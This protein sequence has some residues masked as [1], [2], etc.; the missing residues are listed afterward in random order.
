MINRKKYRFSLSKSAVIGCLTAI[1]LLTS[2]GTVAFAADSTNTSSAIQKQSISEKLLIDENTKFYHNFDNF[3][4]RA[5]F[6]FKVP[7]YAVPE[8]S[9]SKTLEIEKIDNNKNYVKISFKNP[10]KNSY[11][12]WADVEN[13]KDSLVRDY[14]IFKDDKAI[15]TSNAKNIGSIQGEDITGISTDPYGN[16]VKEKYFA[17]QNDG[18]YYSIKYYCD[19]YNNILMNL[20]DDEL[21]KIA[22]SIKNPKETTNINYFKKTTLGNDFDHM[23]I[24]YEE[25]LNEA[26]NILGFKPKLVI[27]NSIRPE[28]AYLDF[29]YE[30]EDD[31]EKKLTF[32]SDYVLDN[33]FHFELIQSKDSTN[34][35]NIKKEQYFF[36][37]EKKKSGMN[38][39][40]EKLNINNKDVYKAK[41]DPIPD[42]ALNLYSYVY[43][44]EDN[45]IY[46]ELYKDTPNTSDEAYLEKA[47]KLMLD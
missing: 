6:N 22:N 14:K 26:S 29:S 5:E 44:F 1:S 27:N 2:T 28:H 11:E 7:D 10:Q 19:Y 35:D 42:S 17:W 34:Y 41:L 23:Y 45:G 16:K 33:N 13:I 20:N 37:S 25:D 18:I 43:T 31:A 47:V 21:L 46:Y 12:F 4:K 24:Y 30:D 36:T 3:I 39:T 38:I 15:V 40:T 9:L 8:Y 32:K